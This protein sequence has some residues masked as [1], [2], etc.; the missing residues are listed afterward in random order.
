MI[1]HARRMDEDATPELKA[2]GQAVRG[3]LLIPSASTPTESLDASHDNPTTAPLAGLSEAQHE[4]LRA[5]NAEAQAA[6]AMSQARR[7]ARSILPLANEVGGFGYRLF[8]LATT[9]LKNLAE[10]NYEDLKAALLAGYEEERTLDLELLDLFIALRA[11]TYVGWIVP[12]MSE[13][14]AEARNRRFIETACRLCA[15]LPI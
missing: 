15:R 14:G 11:S 8:D 5:Y 6:A 10:P 7:D 9:L 4:A 13:N 1:R 3:S 12:R 2:V